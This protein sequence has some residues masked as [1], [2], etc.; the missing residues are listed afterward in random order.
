MKSRLLKVALVESYDNRTFVGW[1]AANV[2]KVAPEVAALLDT[3]GP[4]ED[5]VVDVCRPLVDDAHVHHVAIRTVENPAS[6]LRPGHRPR[7]SQR[8]LQGISPV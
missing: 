5:V 2:V 8:V 7:E 1:Y 4:G 6:L 3:F